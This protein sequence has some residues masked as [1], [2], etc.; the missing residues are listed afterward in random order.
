[1][2][3]SLFY[4]LFIFL[5]CQSFFSFSQKTIKEID[6]IK[7][8]STALAGYELYL[9]SNKLSIK[10]QLDVKLRITTRACV[11]HDFSRAIAIGNESIKIAKANAL[12]SL[13]GAFKKILGIT[14]YFIGEPK[15]ASDY[16]Q[17]AIK[18]AQQY[19]LWF[20]EATCYNNLGAL[21]IDS[22]EYAEA[23]RSLITS[24]KIM[25]QHHMEEH[26]SVAITYRLLATNYYELKQPKKA[27][28]IYR[29]LIEEARAKNDTS[30][31]CGE[32]IYYSE[33]LAARGDTSE[34]LS[35]SAEAL[36]YLRHTYVASDLVSGL[37]RHA[38]NLIAVGRYKEAMPLKDEIYK[39]QRKTFETDLQKQI[40]EVEVKYKTES[41]QK[42]KEAAEE[43]TKK[44]QWIYLISFSIILIVCGFM[45]YIFNQRKNTKV[46]IASQQQ[47]LEAIIEGEEKERSR[48]AK[49][50]HD[51][52]VQDLTAIK[53]KL[54]ANP[55]NELT[56]T[57]SQDIDNA[58]KEVRDIAYQMMPIALR[59]YG[60]IISLEGLL[61]KTLGPKQINFEFEPV[62]ITE[63]L[64]E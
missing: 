12:D 46:K 40:S 38:K 33:L 51:G 58:A 11:S 56:K 13:D 49:D 45:I 19:D 44:Q 30:Q 18:V 16:F 17:K 54:Q 64:S 1:M 59:E 37:S 63:R 4:S 35:M 6:H 25:Q 55:Q 3:K 42:E 20:I 34:A 27:E 28:I 39:I 5:L 52:I 24:I 43:N 2:L 60:L 41:I 10:Q 15:M 8:D 57:I 62:N 47:R 9:H 14:Y 36:R 29:K 48:I 61:Q 32:L 23:E 21:H 50:L 31:I 26:E 22:K 7:N 53:L